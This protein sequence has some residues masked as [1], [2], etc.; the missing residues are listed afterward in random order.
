MKALETG[1]ELVQILR[2]DGISGLW[3]H[4]KE[5]FSDLK[6]TVMDAVTDM[7]QSQV[8]QAGIKWILG[9]LTP[10]GAFVKA[11]MAIID[12]VKFFV[13]RAAQIMELVQAFITGVKAVASGS[14]KAVA[15]AIE[16]ALGKAIPVVIGFLASLLGIGGLA[17]KVIG[18]FKKI[19]ER[20]EK[21]LIA[22]WTKIKTLGANLLKKVGI[23][24][25]EKSDEKAGKLE[26]NEVGKVIHFKD[27]VEDHELWI[28]VN[29]GKVEV[30]VA[31][32]NPRPV[33]QRITEWRNRLDELTDDK[34]E[35]AVVLLA[36]AE[37]LN[38]ETL[39]DAA[40]S[41]QTLR[42][43]QKEKSD[44]AVKK[45]KEKDDKLESDEDKLKDIVLQLFRLF[46]SYP[47]DAE[48]KRLIEVLEKM[49]KVKG[50]TGFA[51][52]LKGSKIPAFRE[53]FKTQAKR[54]EHYY[55]DDL[56]LQIEKIEEGTRVDLVIKSSINANAKDKDG[57][58][59]IEVKHWTGFDSLDKDTKLI[60]LRSLENQLNNYLLANKNVQLEWKGSI[61][62]FVKLLCE[63]L[64]IK[65][66]SI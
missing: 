15:S 3:E 51:G 20:V 46:N 58:I 62:D 32:S 27:D 50:A 40:W 13:Q 45:A 2:T 38:K 8:V 44:T 57:Q 48:S 52:T 12:V 53:G 24:K 25:K 55:K 49:V 47:L 9:L 29:N 43:A 61:P 64:L 60:R 22:L 66:I 6:E 14:I 1:S 17:Q 21:G 33:K 11:A 59:Y 63:D 54:A 10:A 35:K 39:Q 36:K 28:A 16:S 34:K 18:I 31:S 42:D 56:L 26:D 37:D 41:Y 65:V 5:Q 30:M 4:I 19:H 23:G 7:I